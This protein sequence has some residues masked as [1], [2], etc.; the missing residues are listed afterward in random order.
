[1]SEPKKSLLQD[2]I[3]GMAT[4]KNR[5][6]SPGMSQERTEQRDANKDR[7]YMKTVK[8][9]PTWTKT[10]ETMKEQ[11]VIAWTY[12][13]ELAEQRREE[14][15]SNQRLH[16]Q[17]L[18]EIDRL[19]AVIESQAEINAQWIDRLKDASAIVAD[20]DKKITD[21]TA[22]V[23]ERDEHIRG[24]ESRTERM[25]VGRQERDKEI[26]RLSWSNGEQVK[27]IE[28]LKSELESAM[29]WGREQ[30]QS[31]KAAKQAWYD[32]LPVTF[33]GDATATNLKAEIERLR[34]ALEEA[35]SDIYELLINSESPT[36]IEQYAPRAK[37]EI[38]AALKGA[39]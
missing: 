7:E 24:L 36:F 35:E 15:D 38:R 23:Q 31:A 8:M 27:E 11:A 3:E 17:S 29:K 34:A 1:M 32:A 39:E 12:W 22:K 10:Y 19:N 14:R 2:M 21:L 9:L 28:R 30:R 37:A 16:I 26:E 4:S 6:Q 33:D 5:K 25:E 20:R 13:M 18:A